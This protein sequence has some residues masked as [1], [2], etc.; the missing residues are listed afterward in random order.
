MNSFERIV[1]WT[2]WWA[3]LLVVCYAYEAENFG[4]LLFESI[5]RHGR[6]TFPT[7]IHAHLGFRY[8]ITLEYGFV[9]FLGNLTVLL[10]L[11]ATLFLTTGHRSWRILGFVVCAPWLIWSFLLPRY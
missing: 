2:L 9:E 1:F 5:F 6:L 10:L 11:F 3:M 8:N 7:V 4:Y